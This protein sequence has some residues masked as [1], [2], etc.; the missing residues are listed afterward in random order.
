M[1]SFSK[2]LMTVAVGFAIWYALRWYTRKPARR[3][4]PPPRR[5]DAPAASGPVEDLFACTVCGDYAPL[6]AAPCTRAD[7]PRR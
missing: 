1:M 2:I 5:R 6:G 3:G 7:C 4:A